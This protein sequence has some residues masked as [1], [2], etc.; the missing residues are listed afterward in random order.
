[1]TGVEILAMEEVVT[2]TSYNGGAF[3]I[4]SIII[5]AIFL[6][7][8]VIIGFNENDYHY[9]SIAAIFGV[10]CGV[11]AGFIVGAAMGIPVEYTNQ[12]KVTVSDDVQ[13][14]KFNE[15]YEIIEQEGKIYTVRERNG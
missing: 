3:A 12:Y 9:T 13:L 6:I 14:N 7:I 1:M 11:F 15:K 5:F 10:L 4:C 8:G 2:K